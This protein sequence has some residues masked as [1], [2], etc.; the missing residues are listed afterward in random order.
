MTNWKDFFNTYR[1]VNIKGDGDLLY[2]VGITVGGKPISAPQFNAIVDSIKNGLQL[3]TDDVVLDLC[4]GNGVITHELAKVARSVTG[5]DSSEPYIANAKAFKNAANIRYILGDVVNVN[6][7]KGELPDKRNNK[8]LLYAS[9]AYLTPEDLG[10]ILSGLKEI[11]TSRTVIMI[12][13]V[14]DAN[15]KWN[16]FNTCSRRM[17][18]VFK[19]RLLG[20]DTGV[21]RWWTPQEI[22]A[23]ARENDY[24]CSLVRQSPI[25]HTAHYRFDAVLSR[26]S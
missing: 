25:M 24:A 23:I 12:G 14:L 9:L 7:W 17:I 20:R 5:I 18:Y 15:R 16:F 1:L 26:I 3:V 22:E 6:A 8:V 10:R 2:Q 4:C 11:T 19:Y 13:S 21:G